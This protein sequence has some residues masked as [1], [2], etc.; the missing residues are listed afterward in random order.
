MFLGMLELSARSCTGLKTGSAEP[1]NSVVRT[2]GPD[3]PGSPCDED[4]DIY[5]SAVALH[6]TG[7][8]QTVNNVVS[9]VGPGGPGNETGSVADVP[10][11]VI[12][13]SSECWEIDKGTL[14]KLRMLRVN[15]QSESKVY[16]EPSHSITFD[17]GV[18]AFGLCP[19][20]L[21]CKLDCPLLN[22]YLFVFLSG[23]LVTSRE[24]P[25]LANLRRYCWEPGGTPSMVGFPHECTPVVC[26]DFALKVDPYLINRSSDLVKRFRLLCVFGGDDVSSFCV[27]MGLFDR[28]LSQPLSDVGIMSQ[29][30]TLM[31]LDRFCLREVFQY[32]LVCARWCQ[33][34]PVMGT[35]FP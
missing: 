21:M 23:W 1:V 18:F 16:Y 2:S 7:S 12:V 20:V 17:E 9:I 34:A 10:G 19:P 27:P 3:G 15:P 8:D 32:G 35:A 22:P 31:C 30:F 11:D 6:R 33:L 29:V 4:S 24:Q 14:G 13:M 25:V 26:R 28:T 5:E